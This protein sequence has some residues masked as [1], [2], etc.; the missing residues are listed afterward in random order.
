VRQRGSFFQPASLCKTLFLFPKFKA[1]CGFRPLD[2][3]LPR[4]QR[5]DRRTTHPPLD[6]TF[7]RRGQLL[8]LFHKKRPTLSPE[9][10]VG[11]TRGLSR[12]RSQGQS[13]SR[14]RRKTRSPPITN[15]AFSISFELLA[16]P[17]ASSYLRFL[18]RL[19]VR[20]NRAVVIVLERIIT[21]SWEWTT[22]E[23][24]GG[25]MSH[26]QCTVSG[27]LRGHSSGRDTSRRRRIGSDSQ[28]WEHHRRQGRPGE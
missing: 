10:G 4:L 1:L 16:H 2:A 17:V 11:N 5:K 27:I 12:H 25:R 19:E 18:D 28:R 22:A 3:F 7:R 9:C 23:A 20:T 14:S 26:H 24:R 15:G 6:D 8:P 13:C 21:Q